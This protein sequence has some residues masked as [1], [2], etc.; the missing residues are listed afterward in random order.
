MSSEP[1]APSQPNP[2]SCVYTQVPQK[3][4]DD[5]VYLTQAN[6]S[7]SSPASPVD[8]NPKNNTCN[9]GHSEDDEALPGLL[10]HTLPP[11]LPLYP[12][13]LECNAAQAGAAYS[14]TLIRHLESAKTQASTQAVAYD[15]KSVGLFANQHMIPTVDREDERSA[16]RFHQLVSEYDTIIN[17]T[18]NRAA[19]FA[20]TMKRAREFQESNLTTLHNE[21]DGSGYVYDDD[22]L[23]KRKRSRQDYCLSMPSPLPSSASAGPKGK[24]FK[25]ALHLPPPSVL[26]VPM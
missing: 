19:T 17:R 26:V 21:W 20:G 10:P 25:I 1:I 15:C 16:L 14:R 5:A 9:D 12:Y 24:S 11:S 2:E 23:K 6:N 4:N 13:G 3:E 7:A 22:D 18:K 8:R